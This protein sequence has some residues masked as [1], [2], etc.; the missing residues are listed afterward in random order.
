[1]EHVSLST[2]HDHMNTG[3]HFLISN[4]DLPDGLAGSAGAVVSAP[5]TGA[6]A[7]AGAAAAGASVIA[8]GSVIVVKELSGETETSKKEMKEKNRSVRHTSTTLVFCSHLFF[9]LPQFPFFLPWTSCEDD[10]QPTV[11]GVVWE[12]RER[13]KEG[14]MVCVCVHA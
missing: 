2:S 8:V 1:M 12:N 14:E 7:G 3:L 13:E 6:A 4:G 9:S 5:A 10:K 11:T